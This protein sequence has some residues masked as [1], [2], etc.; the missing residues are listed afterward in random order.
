MSSRGR[1]L[2][3]KASTQLAVGLSQSAIAY[4][5]AK[6]QVAKGVDPQMASAHGASVSVAVW[7]YI[8]WVAPVMLLLALIGSSNSAFNV[9]RLLVLGV[10]ILI[11]VRMRKWI[12]DGASNVISYR[13]STRA[14]V[15][16]GGV[17]VTLGFIAL[18]LRVALGSP[19]GN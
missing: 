8:L 11:F 18:F 2:M 16:I 3:P 17:L 10:G 7:M 1:G 5:V 12:D 14:L 13:M 6:K 4:N 19:V 15:I 9:Y